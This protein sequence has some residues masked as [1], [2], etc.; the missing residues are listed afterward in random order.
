MHIRNAKDLHKALNTLAREHVYV[1]GPES[2]GRATRW[3]GC[4]GCE[5]VATVPVNVA[6][7]LCE[8]CLA[9]CPHADCGL[10]AHEHR[11]GCAPIL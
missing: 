4:S 5:A 1:H 11:G 9:P 3:L 7:Y 2:E 8:D 6:S 10:L